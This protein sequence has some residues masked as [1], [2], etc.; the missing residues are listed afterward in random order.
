VRTHTGALRARSSKLRFLSATLLLSCAPQ[1]LDALMTR[2][3]SEDWTQPRGAKSSTNKQIKITLQ[4]SLT[5]AYQCGHS[6]RLFRAE[7]GA[8][9]AYASNTMPLDR[10]R[11]GALHE[12]ERG[13]AVNSPIRDR[14]L[15]GEIWDPRSG[16][17][18]T[19]S[20]DA[21]VA[22]EERVSCR[23]LG[24]VAFRGSTGSTGPSR[25]R[26]FV[27]GMAAFVSACEARSWWQKTLQP[28]ST[29]AGNC[30]SP[31]ADAGDAPLGILVSAPWTRWS[32]V[33][34]LPS[35]PGM[36]SRS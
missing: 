20:D 6:H 24:A 5:F 17:F 16:P 29:A 10:R 18:L 7:E 35:R 4:T 22:L 15:A 3:G 23:R 9:T 26:E 28:D 27:R 19:T 36:G 25:A 1:L 13:G 30:L 21:G 31:F 2:A 12:P 32:G 14:D 11:E 34:A 8:C 33:A